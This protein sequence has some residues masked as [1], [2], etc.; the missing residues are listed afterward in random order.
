MFSKTFLFERPR[1]LVVKISYEIE[2][3]HKCLRDFLEQ[4]LYRLWQDTCAVNLLHLMWATNCLASREWNTDISPLRACA[5]IP[6][7]WIPG[8]DESLVVCQKVIGNLGMSWVF[9]S[10]WSP[11]K[12][13]RST[14]PAD[15]G[16]FGNIAILWWKLQLYGWILHSNTKSPNPKM[17]CHVKPDEINRRQGSSSSSRPRSSLCLSIQNDVKL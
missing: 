15:A 5:R 6:E 4:G 9:W 11:M 14:L 1:R 8:L 12:Y 10:L 2:L 16:K 17:K 13:S 3:F 7:R